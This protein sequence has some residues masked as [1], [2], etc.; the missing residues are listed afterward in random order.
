MKRVVTLTLLILVFVLSSCTDKD[1]GI[2]GLASFATEPLPVEDIVSPSTPAIIESYNITEKSYAL[3][4]EIQFEMIFNKVITITSG[5]PKLVLDIGGVSRDAILVSGSGTNKFTFSYTTQLGDIDIDGIGLAVDLD[6]SIIE[7]EDSLTPI[8]LMP[9]LDLSNVLVD[10]QAPTITAL[11]PPT[12]GVYAATSKINFSIQFDE[13]VIVTGEPQIPFTINTTIV[14]AKYISGN[15][16]NTLVFEYEVL[17]SEEDTDGIDYADL[18]INSGSIQDASGNSA[19]TTLIASN[20][21]NVKVDAIAPVADS[22]IINS[23]EAYVTDNNLTLNLAATDATE[24][25]LTENADC[26]TGGTWENFSAT[27]AHA[28]TANN[29]VSIYYKVRDEAQNESACISS[30]TIH[31]NQAPN[32]VSSINLANNG[33]DIASDNSSWSAPTDNGPSGVATYLYATS[34]TNDETGIV[35]GGAWTNTLAAISFQFESGL[36]L[37]GSTNYFTLVKAVDNAG[38]ISTITAS[39]PWQI[40]V[41]PE[42][43]TNLDITNATTESLSIGWA[44]PQDN[45]TAITDYNIQIK[46]GVYSDW[47]LYNDG[48]S[49]A[50]SAT[51]SGLDPETTYQIKVRGFNGINYSGWS[52]TRTAD[53]LPNITFFEPGFKAINIS[54][55][56]KSK[57]VSFADNNQI[58]LNGTLVTTLAKHATY[59]FDSAEFDQLEATEAFYVAGK[60]G[61]GSGSSDQGNATWAT[62]SWVGKEFFF[63]FTRATPLKVKV[64]AFTDSTVTITKAGV[65]EATQVITAGTGHT[66]SIAAYAGYEMVSTG[67]IVAFA[68][69]NQENLFYDP[70]PILPASTD[71]IGIPSK[72]AKISSGTSSNAYTAEHSDGVTTSS[73][74]TAG[75]IVSISERSAGLGTGLYKGAALRVRAD[76]PIMAVS[77]ADSDGYCQAPFVPVSMLK[78]KF[79]LNADSEFVAFASDRPVTVTITKPDLTTSTVTLTRSGSGAKTPYKAYLS[80]SYPEGTLFEGSDVM[81]AWYQPLT[82]TYSGGDDETIMFGWD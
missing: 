60:L 19:V 15:T 55:A 39:A 41:S 42:A 82:S 69:G 24:M 54:G 16:T 65:F 48:V 27:K 10:T 79:G 70:V 64:F 14:N 13:N 75:V 35:T 49:T 56:P 23:G 12:D 30:T 9:T 61:T 34:T 5:A 11:T 77:N 44:Y 46:G 26:S 33:S 66:F 21:A 32:A 68:Y 81:Q 4:Q 50:T 37:I 40:I 3:A 53:T 72:T 78:K 2:G 36:T 58:Y 29:T 67:Y 57:L 8:F 31:D 71:I 62:Q 28:M 1:S 43:I 45:G 59:E 73:T 17:A 20:L 63:N 52:N 80:T 47:T 18:D 74:L 22:I 76:E 51:I 38:N 7:D 25:Y 6:S